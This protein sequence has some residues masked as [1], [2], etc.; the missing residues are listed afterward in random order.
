MKQTKAGRDWFKIAALIMAVIVVL[1]IVSYLWFPFLP[2]FEQREAGEEIVKEQMDADKALQN[3]RWFREQY[4]DIEAKREQI[5]NN[6]DELER[7]YEIQGKNPDN[8]SRTAEVRHGRIQERITGN[9]QKL[10]SMVAEYNARSDDATR[11]IWKCH[12]PFQVDERFA[13]QGPPGSDA[14]EQPQDQYVDGA[15]P[16]QTPPEASQCD[17]LP[18]E[19]RQQADS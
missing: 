16:D 4:R 1:I 14:P 5:Q 9:Q 3:Y 7:F 18:K 15:D 17:G 11:A 12:L 2:W 13:I 8:W 19:V 6:Y 10:E